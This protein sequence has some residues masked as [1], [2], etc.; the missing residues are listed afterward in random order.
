MGCKFNNKSPTIYNKIVF[1]SM[2]YCLFVHSI[3]RDELYNVVFCH[4]QKVMFCGVRTYLWMYENKMEVKENMRTVDTIYLSIIY[5]DFNGHNLHWPRPRDKRA[6]GNMRH[7]R[8][9]KMGDVRVL[10]ERR[11][12]KS[13][14]SDRSQRGISK[15]AHILRHTRDLRI[16]RCLN[17]RKQA[18]F[19][20]PCT[21]GLDSV[22]SG[23][24]RCE[25]R[26]TVMVG[27][28]Y[29]VPKRFW[30]G[31]RA[32]GDIQWYHEI[33]TI[34]DMSSGL[35][36]LTEQSPSHVSKVHPHR[37]NPLKL[38]AFSKRKFEKFEACCWLVAKVARCQ[39]NLVIN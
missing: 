7:L 3:D 12:N 13:L 14:N 8:R 38:R 30:D 9:S 18:S 17:S 5:D 15:Q 36:Y 32:I 2:P 24:E 4:Y 6:A 21:H 19:N 1:S 11:D 27:R 39:T 16:N 25:I 22:K 20:L 35:M 33:G 34:Q 31:S 26:E 10:R 23:S 28:L 29:L 37:G